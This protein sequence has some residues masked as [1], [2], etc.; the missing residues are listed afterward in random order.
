MKIIV[1]IKQVP[2]THK[3]KTDPVTGTLIREGV[4]SIINPADKNAI[5]AALQLKKTEDVEVIALSMGPIQA[6][7]A[8]RETLAMGVDKAVLLNDFSFA[9]SDT[10][11]TSLTLGTAIKKLGEFDLILCGNQAI[12]GDT[13]QVGPQIAEFLDLPQV[14]CVF[15]LKL[16]NKNCFVSKETDDGYSELLVKLPVLLTVTKKLN[17]PRYCT[18]SNIKK[19]F[20]KQSVQIWN[21]QDLNLDKNNVGLKGSPTQVKRSFSPQPKEEGVILKGSSLEKVKQLLDILNL[22][23]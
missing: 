2:D 21:L 7:N 16:S 18:I 22:E 3:V 8:L 9:G 1:C 23:L 17:K 13:A 20:R 15:K 6:E 19:S 14:S 4:Q 5:E 12:D 10:S 11:A